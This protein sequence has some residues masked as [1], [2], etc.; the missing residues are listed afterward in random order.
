MNIEIDHIYNMDCL[1]GMKDIPD[2][3]VDCIICDL[4][5]GTTACKWDVLIP[6]DKLWEQYRRILKHQGS[7][8]MFGSEPFSSL[9]RMSNFDWYK[10]DWIW[11]KGTPSGFQHA[12]N[13]PMKDYENICVFSAAAMGHVSRLGDH[14]MTYNPQGLQRMKKPV[15][16]HNKH[17]KFSGT[18]GSRPSNQDTIVREVTNYPRMIQFFDNQCGETMNNKRIHPTQKPADLIQYLIRTYTNEGDVVLDNCMG[19]GTTA[20]AAIREKR[21]YI[22]F[23]LNEEYYKKSLARI[24]KELSQPKLF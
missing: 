7:A 3:S 1:V 21:H 19:S 13:M 18:V 24:K 17:N 15:V 22:G 6:F 5:Y 8:L 12:K 23:E 14:R 11:Q 2:N 16:E 9:L 4:P 20:I 10:Y